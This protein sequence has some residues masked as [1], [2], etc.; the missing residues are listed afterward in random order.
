MP[1]GRV[2]TRSV[3]GSVL[4]PAHQKARSASKQRIGYSACRRVDVA[5]GG[6]DRS[7]PHTQRHRDHPIRAWP[8]LLDLARAAPEVGERI[9]TVSPD[10]SS[11]ANLGGW[12]NKAGVW[13]VDAERRDWFADDGKRYCTGGSARRGG[14]ELGI[15]ETN[16]VSLMGDSVQPGVGGGAIAADRGHVD[17]FVAR[18]LEPWSFGMYAGGHSILIGAPSGV[19][20]APEGGA[21]QSITTPSIGLEQPLCTTWE[22]AFSL[23][24]EWCLLAAIGQLGKLGGGWPPAAVH[25]AGQPGTRRCADRPVA[26]DR[27]RRQVV[28]GGYRLLP[29]A[30]LA[31]IVA[32]GAVVPRRSRRRIGWARWGFPPRSSASRAL[33]FF[34]AEQ[35]RRG[36]GTGDTWIL[37]GLFPRRGRLAPMVTVLDG[38]PHTLAFLAGDRSRPATHL[39]I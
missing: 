8:N 6:T 28:A 15:A 2:S 34:E 17:P 9:V 19:T 4:R 3:R 12:V 21:H 11:S 38:H 33:V 25:Q 30:T 1:N 31:T 23:D 7:R 26:R 22:P 35:A 27:R 13:S 16:L 20:L 37:D 24:T 18:A 14:I 32:M 5:A 29:S 36:M 10:V 39:G